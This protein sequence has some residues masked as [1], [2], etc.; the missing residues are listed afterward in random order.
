[1]SFNTNNFFKS[2]VFLKLFY[3]LK[4]KNKIIFKNINK[5]K[6]NRH[7]YLLTF[8]FSNYKLNNFFY[9]NFFF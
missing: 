8:K 4:I 7:A 3:F 2:I 5:Y 1:M 6:I 9:K